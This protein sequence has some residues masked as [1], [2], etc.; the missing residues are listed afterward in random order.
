MEMVATGKREQ[1]QEHLTPAM[2]MCPARWTCGSDWSRLR[3]RLTNLDKAEVPR[4]VH[5]WALCDRLRSVRDVSSK[6]AKC[7]VFVGQKP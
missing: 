6:D 5:L 3:R 4:N 7:E 1:A 2:T